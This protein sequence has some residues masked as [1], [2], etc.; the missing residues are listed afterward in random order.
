MQKIKEKRTIKYEIDPY[1]RLV[2]IETNKK[3]NITKYRKVLDGK[4]TIN[5]NLLTYNIKQCDDSDIPKQITL[6]GKWFL[7]KNHDL[8]LSLKNQ[9]NKSLN[10]KITLKGEL[11]NIRSN[12]IVFAITT[13]DSKDNIKSYILQ[14]KGVWKTD[15]HNQLIFDFKKE[16]GD[17]NSLLLRGIWLINKNNQLIYT[18]KKTILKTKEKLIS[19][20]IIKGFW[21][22]KDKYT[23]SYILNKTITS[24][25]D[26]RVGIAKQFKNGLKYEIAIGSIPEK[27]IIKL[28]GKWKIKDLDILFEIFYDNKKTKKIVFIADYMFDKKYNILL[29]LKGKTNKNVELDLKLSKKFLKS[30][31]EL[32]VRTIVSKK[33]QQLLFGSGVRW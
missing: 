12:K 21:K 11:I 9:S 25:F 30:Q 28:Y 31:G 7:N 33:E 16:K 24:Q 13:K 20:V 29:K 27:R 22:I 10:N 6:K 2:Y 15:K 8:V 23:I 4:F 17:K 3:S 26:F 19:T 1:N 5:N 18:Y 32:F 14:F